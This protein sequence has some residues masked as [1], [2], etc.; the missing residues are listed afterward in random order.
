MT[1]KIE[2]FN[3]MYRNFGDILK[4]KQS[5]EQSGYFSPVEYPVDHHFP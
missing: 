5:Y 2:H 3:R 1:S 4:S